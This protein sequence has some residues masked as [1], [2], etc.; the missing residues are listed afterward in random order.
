[1]LY[2]HFT[3]P[4]IDEESFQSYITKKKDTY[5]NLREEPTNYFY[6]KYNRIRSQ[7]HPRGNYLPY[8][9]DWDKIDFE[10]AVE[11]YKERFANAAEFTFVI[12]GAIDIEKTKELVSTYLGSLPTTEREVT[13]KDLGIRPPA[14]F[15]TEKIYKGN[16]PK[17]LAILSFEK[18]D[19]YNE[20]D[21]F[22]VGQVGQI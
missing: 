18:E 3:D 11:I 7:N 13:Y 21:R 22:L 14:G 9:E 16:D 19:K 5:K 2:L 17:S 15:V 8:D 12:V 6:D 20:K 4:R 10:R 1:M